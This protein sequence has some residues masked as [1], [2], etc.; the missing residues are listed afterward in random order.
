M[1]HYLFTLLINTPPPTIK[2]S[3]YLKFF[4]KTITDFFFSTSGLNASKHLH[5]SSFTYRSYKKFNR[6]DIFYYCCTALLIIFGTNFFFYLH[7]FLSLW[8]NSLN[9][10]S[11]ITL[12][13]ILLRLVMIN[14]KSNNSEKDVS[15]YFIFHHPGIRTTSWSPY[16]WRKSFVV[17]EHFPSHVVQA[18]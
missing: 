3:F 10:L 12:M 4:L 11:P 13:E 1:G 7:F 14:L 15:S 6:F 9:Y 16:G 2:N 18:M 5:S 17:L 8:N